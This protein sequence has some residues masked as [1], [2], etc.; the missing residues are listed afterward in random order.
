LQITNDAN[1]LKQA[2]ERLKIINKAGDLQY[3]LIDSS[4]ISHLPDKLMIRSR[5]FPEA[6]GKVRPL[7]FI[8]HD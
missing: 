5:I 8:P 1:F 6:D 7:F 2:F 3:L 4:N